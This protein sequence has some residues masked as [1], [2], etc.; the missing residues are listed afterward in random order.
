VLEEWCGLADL[1]EQM[2]PLTEA[3][4]RKV[5]VYLSG[6]RGLDF[7]AL[8]TKSD[9]KLCEFKCAKTFLD[10]LYRAR[11]MP[12]SK[13][14]TGC[15]NHGK[16]L[17]DPLGGRWRRLINQVRRDPKRLEAAGLPVPNT[18]DEVEHVFS[19]PEFHGSETARL[20]GN[21]AKK[22]K[23]K[24]SNIRS[25]PHHFVKL[26]EEE[27]T[28]E[29]PTTKPQLDR[30]DDFRNKTLTELPLKGTLSAREV[31]YKDDQLGL[32]ALRCACHACMRDDY[33]A[34]PA[35]AYTKGEPK[36]SKFRFS[37]SY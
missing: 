12:R 13:A 14:W 33:A 21:R 11:R 34:C 8:H 36:W 15:P 22:L 1:A 4:T 23:M 6:E 20:Y 9:N 16:C 27:R 5:E 3:C 10:F 19:D 30:L 18:S 35:I 25:I 28:I 37:Y 24:H 2:A 31:L 17:C 29:V 26:C 32:R 7:G